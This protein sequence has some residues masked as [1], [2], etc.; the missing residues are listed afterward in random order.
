MN[1]LNLPTTTTTTTSS[2]ITTNVLGSNDA[3]SQGQN[4]DP[5]SNQS[6][7]IQRSESFRQRVS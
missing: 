3:I 6:Q 4:V 7:G 2:G 5:Q 1:D